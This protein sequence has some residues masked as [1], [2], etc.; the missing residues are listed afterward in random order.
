SQEEWVQ[1]I[2]T[3]A[4][5]REVLLDQ[6]R[7][8][9][10]RGGDL[11]RMLANSM[12]NRE[13][14]EY[15]A[16][17]PEGQAL[18]TEFQR[19]ERGI[20]KLQEEVSM[21]ESQANH[22]EGALMRAMVV[23]DILNQYLTGKFQAGEQSLAQQRITV[24]KAA[25]QKL[26]KMY[27]MKGNYLHG[28]DIEYLRKEAREK[29]R[30]IIEHA[31]YVVQERQAKIRSKAPRYSFNSDPKIFEDE[32]ESLQQEFQQDAEG[33]QPAALRFYKNIRAEVLET[34]EQLKNLKTTAMQIAGIEGG[35]DGVTDR[36]ATSGGNERG[37]EEN[38]VSN[39]SMLSDIM[40]RK[41]E[42]G[43]EFAVQ[44]TIGSQL[45]GGTTKAWLQNQQQEEQRAGMQ[46]QVASPQSPQNWPQQNQMHAVRP[47]S[48]TSFGPPQSQLPVGGHPSQPQTPYRRPLMQPQQ[49][50]MR[51]SPDS[52]PF[53]PQQGQFSGT[54]MPAFQTPA[55]Q[56]NARS[57]SQHPPMMP[58]SQPNMPAGSP[59]RSFLPRGYQQQVSS[60]P[61]SPPSTMPAGNFG[62]LGVNQ[63]SQFASRTMLPP[64]QS[65]GGM[66][67]RPKAGPSSQ[68]NQVPSNFTV[69]RMQPPSALRPGPQQ[70]MHAP[71]PPFSVE[72]MN[73]QMQQVMRPQQGSMPP[74]Q[75][76]MQ[77]QM[78]RHNFP[79]PQST[80]ST[81]QNFPWFP[82]AGAGPQQTF[83]RSPQMNLVPPNLNRPPPYNMAS[84]QMGGP[85]QSGSPRP[86]PRPS[87]QLEGL[88][89]SSDRMRERREAFLRLWR[90][91][92]FYTI[93]R[94]VLRWHYCP[95]VWLFPPPIS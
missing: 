76:R 9:R 93:V 61:Q 78:A 92:P 50:G 54:Q 84:P 87:G 72:G 28:Q 24:E 8:A 73:A 33:T 91:G 36:A 23:W 16:C 64:Q 80:S 89:G 22:E 70:L 71:T 2:K 51:P 56:G 12:G 75:G 34:A 49:P 74:M 14:L 79:G 43:R 15:G 40:K 60:M 31:L 62:Q 7:R 65:P 95:P 58:P 88:Q 83:N 25:V 53:M 82:V 20:I 46:N 11:R 66:I 63:Q 94:G 26:Y 13:M 32:G 69:Q 67:V 37:Y 90:P 35:N 18:M 77:P 59:A 47:P 48:E 44:D 42:A 52:F 4:E 39:S 57:M 41:G 10:W 19:V 38:M 85:M 21:S 5:T 30:Y 27:Q 3:A 81:P 6:L 1:R 45:V 17:G 55:S 86:P 29:L 68:A